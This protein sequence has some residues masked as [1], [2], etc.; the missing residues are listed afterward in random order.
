MDRIDGLISVLL[1]FAAEGEPPG[2]DV[3]DL[4]AELASALDDLAG[5]VSPRSVAVGEL[6]V[7]RGDAAQLRSVLMNLLDNAAKFT[8]DGDTPDLEVD[9]TRRDGR[10]RIE[11]RDRGRG[12]PEGQRERIFAPLTRLDKTVAGV[13]IGLA[14]CRRIVEAHGG[15]MGVEERAGGGSVFWFE[16][17]V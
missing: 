1:S 2:E 14:T 5:R 7:V 9:A 4:R 10:Q 3:V 11:V 15:T 8:E 6:P 16:L 13:G 17:P 12:V